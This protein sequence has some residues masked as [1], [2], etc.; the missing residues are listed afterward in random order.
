MTPIRPEPSR[1]RVR[2]LLTPAPALRTTKE[3]RR[4]SAQIPAGLRLAAAVSAEISR[5]GAGGEFDSARHRVLRWI[6]AHTGPLP[7]S[8]DAGPT[9]SGNRCQVKRH[10]AAGAAVRAVDRIAGAARHFA[11]SL[12]TGA[13][14]GSI[15]WKAVAILCRAGGAT[16]VRVALLT[17]PRRIR[18]RMSVLWVPEIVH[19]LARSPGLIDYG[20]RILPAP[21]IVRD[22]AGVEDLIRLI[23]DPERTR[24]VFATGL[25]S[26]ETNP[27]T[28][29]LDPWDLAHHTAGLAHVVVLTGP[30]TY[31]LSDLVGRRFSVFGNAIRTYR[32]GCVIGDEATEHPMALADTVR[33]WR[34]GG[35]HEFRVFLTREAARISVQLQALQTDPVPEP[36]S[37]EIGEEARAGARGTAPRAGAMLDPGADGDGVHPLG[38]GEDAAAPEETGAAPLAEARA[39]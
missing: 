2:P 14:S 5:D 4:R 35:P 19:G 11:A 12:A 24:P 6:E 1:L 17:P 38:A 7:A 20:W 31:V 8:F 3:W 32:P 23:A 21:W 18:Q 16:Q 10:R 30:M 25:E 33:R 36:L 27:E 22:R 34:A 26:G 13:A 29:P 15:V 28:A 9:L 39:G 37:G